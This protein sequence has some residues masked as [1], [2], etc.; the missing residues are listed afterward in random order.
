M[1][2]LPSVFLTLQSI[3]Q[4][5]EVIVSTPPSM[6]ILLDMLLSG[7][8]A[9]WQGLFIYNSVLFGCTMVKTLKTRGTTRFPLM[10]IVFRNGK[11]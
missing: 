9:S 7:M 2:E 3:D 8:A 10:G 6:A 4:I 1:S 5:T 11:L